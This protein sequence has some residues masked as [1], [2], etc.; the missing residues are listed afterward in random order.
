MGKCLEQIQRVT[1]CHV[2]QT[3]VVF[4]PFSNESSNPMLSLTN[5][6]IRQIEVRMKQSKRIYELIY[7][8][9]LKIS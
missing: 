6:V 2:K 4:M 8:L 1:S 9:Q 3:Q 7:A 5:M